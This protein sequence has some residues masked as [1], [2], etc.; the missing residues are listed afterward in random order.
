MT[1]RCSAFVFDPGGCG[2][3]SDDNCSL[4]RLT[5]SSDSS[6]T[7]CSGHQ[8]DDCSINFMDYIPQHRLRADLNSRRRRRLRRNGRRGRSTS[9]IL[10]S[11]SADIV[12]AAEA[13]LEAELGSAPFDM[14]SSHSD[15][16]LS[17]EEASSISDNDSLPE[18]ASDSGQSDDE[19]GIDVA[20]K[21]RL[22]EVAE[23]AAAVPNILG[24][25]APRFGAVTKPAQAV[26]VDKV[27]YENANVKGGYKFFLLAY[28]L[29]GKS[30]AIRHCKDSSQV[31]H[32][33]ASMCSQHGWN[34][35]GYLSTIF[36]DGEKAFFDQIEL[37][38]SRLIPTLAIRDLPPH[39]PASNAVENIVRHIR[40]FARTK[41]LA[42]IVLG[43]PIDQTFEPFALDDA[44]YVYNR[45]SNA[46]LPGGISPF[47]YETGCQ[48]DYNFVPFGCPGYAHI[49]ASARRAR[50][51]RHEPVA[52]SEDVL[53]IGPSSAFSSHYRCLTT[54]RTQIGT[55]SV[56]WFPERRLGLFPSRLCEEAIPDMT[57]EELVR[58]AEDVI[59]RKVSDKKKQ[60]E[61]TQKILSD[62][63]SHLRLVGGSA[64]P[65]AP[66]IQMRIADMV[67]ITVKEA[68][69]K[70][71]I[72]SD[73][74]VLKYR[75]KDLQYD[76][77][78]DFLRV[79]YEP[80]AMDYNEHTKDCFE[81]YIEALHNETTD[82]GGML[83]LSAL[84]AVVA[85]KDLSWPKYLKSEDRDAVIAAWDKEVRALIDL[86]ALRELFPD[87]AEFEEAKRSAT[88]CRALLDIK[89]TG[90]FK[91]R[92]VAQGF[93]EDKVKLDG[94]H[95]DYAANVAKLSSIRLDFLRPAR[96]KRRVSTV[97]IANAYLQSIPFAEDDIRYLS[98]KD[99]VTGAIRYFRQ[100]VPIYGQASSAKRWEET[101]SQWL[102]TPESEGGAGFVRGMNEKGIFYHPTR[103]ILL[104]L[105]V[106]DCYVSAYDEDSEWFYT[107][108]DKRKGGRFRTKDPHWLDE[109]TSIDHLGMVMHMDEH[110][111]YLSMQN[112]IESMYEVLNMQPPSKFPSRP[113]DH[114]V[115]D[116][117]PI[118][119][120]EQKFFLKGLGMVLWLG[121]TTRVDV[122][123][124]HSRIA[125]YCCSPCR[126]ALN[127]LVQTIH[128][129]YGT[130]DLCLRQH[131]FNAAYWQFFSDSDQSAN[132]E[133]INE[134]RSQLAYIAMLGDAPIIWSSKAT[135]V[136]WPTPSQVVNPKP[137]IPV[138]HPLRA[139]FGEHCDI[140]SAAAEIFA[141]AHAVSDFSALS[142][143]ADE[144]GMPFEL[145][146]LLRVDNEAACS[147]I[148]DNALRTKLRHI[149][150]RQ[151][152][153][154]HMRDPEIVDV[155]YIPSKLN[156]SDLLTKIHK[157]ADD[158]IRH[159]DKM[160]FKFQK[161]QAMDGCSGG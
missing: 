114:G 33:F 105:F 144:M 87:D 107:K 81:A 108:L 64:K 154:R 83:R 4:P 133:P 43:G 157:V 62:K 85:M 130:R 126:G 92:L 50:K 46:A 11:F 101:I 69:A 12:R 14:A 142:Y 17:F 16:E 65:K 42:A 158:F 140:S 10:K 137:V 128:Y 70:R 34:R 29:G 98:C 38:C 2:D 59:R 104:I 26:F 39:C 60:Q 75:R 32:A 89:R 146:L 112:Y 88:S 103:D 28:D 121:N 120:E 61:V 94:P 122:R 45:M 9:G 129:L 102:I 143:Q 51:L 115:D 134:G 125:Q 20:P 84:A 49:P 66:Y 161:P 145:P 152:W 15:S 153:V 138:A 151:Y 27:Y 74:R 19:R 40:D 86:G 116:L 41:L 127:N 106:D 78:H 123:H 150:V 23:W 148:R 91:A 117:T 124:A 21:S 132:M 24:P 156:I 95:F 5:D 31:P 80:D 52:R 47:E 67:G 53:Y 76:L 3:S 30:V 48:P 135:S 111:L 118:S 99:P 77:N 147:F 57:P 90:E 97:D 13:N 149:D 8:S 155:E 160:L 131:R 68:L 159:R 55:R 79:K 22:R 72:A 35:R 1:Y 6:D 37:Q 63:D 110:Y 58:F 100:Y 18:L 93:K 73:G 54:R 44:V 7:D 139:P 109:E 82:A 56:K 136:Q 36:V 71:Y 113:I 141:A 96:G 119:A 25:D